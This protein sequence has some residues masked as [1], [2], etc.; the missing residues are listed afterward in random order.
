MFDGNDMT[1]IEQIEEHIESIYMMSP[2]GTKVVIAIDS[3]NDLT[4]SSKTFNINDAR[5]E[6]VAKAIKD[7]TVKYNAVVMCT[8]HLRKTNGR[9]PT[10]DDLKDTIVLQYEANLVFLAYNEVGVKEENASVYWL[11]EDKE[12]KMPVLEMKFGKNKFSSFKGTKF[13]E[14]MP[15]Q[16]YCIEA[17]A[18]GNRRYAA[19]IYQA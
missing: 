17:T 9:R 3:F 5:N 12:E 10:V 19:L 1:S 18:E 14:F 6:Y 13:F 2:D 4:V 7:W 16:S 11:H 8:A 15:D